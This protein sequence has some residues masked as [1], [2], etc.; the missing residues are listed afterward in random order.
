VFTSFLDACYSKDRFRIFGKK[1]KTTWRYYF[2][3]FFLAEISVGPM[4]KLPSDGS[5][6]C[7]V[8]GKIFSQAGNLKQHMVIHTGEKP[9]SCEMCGKSF[10]LKGNLKKHM[11]VHYSF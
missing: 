10:N 7:T 3:S 4:E 1:V 9:F 6:T 2:F 5:H 11:A 8:C